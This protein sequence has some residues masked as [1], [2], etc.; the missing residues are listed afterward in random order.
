MVQ[1]KQGQGVSTPFA[2]GPAGSSMGSFH[3]AIHVG[4]IGRTSAKMSM[5]SQQLESSLDRSLSTGSDKHRVLPKESHGH[6]PQ[7]ALGTASA[8]GSGNVGI[9]SATNR[10]RTPRQFMWRQPQRPW[11]QSLYTGEAPLAEAPEL[12]RQFWT[13]GRP[14]EPTFRTAGNTSSLTERPRHR[15]LGA[16]TRSAAR[17]AHQDAEYLVG[18]CPVRRLEMEP[19]LCNQQADCWWPYNRPRPPASARIRSLPLGRKLPSAQVSV[20]GVSGRK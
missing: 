13:R 10:K 15:Q 16:A 11:A 19:G 2:S 9:T 8:S 4:D 7:C 6:T 5:S 1:R 14:C 3:R 17:G 20:R 18:T 12:S